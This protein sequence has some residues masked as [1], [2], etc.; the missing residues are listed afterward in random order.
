MTHM[1]VPKYFWVMWY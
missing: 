1:H